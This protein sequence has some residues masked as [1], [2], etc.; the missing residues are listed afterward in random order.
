LEASALRSEAN[1][2][3]VPCG[4]DDSEWLQTAERMGAAALRLETVADRFARIAKGFCGYLSLTAQ[5]SEP[6]CAWPEATAN[7][8]RLAYR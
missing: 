2:L 4:P 7:I 5:I 3:A 8:E 6:S 1:C